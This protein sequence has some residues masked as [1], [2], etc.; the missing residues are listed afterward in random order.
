M[1]KKKA[2]LPLEAKQL[3]KH[4][5]KSA[6]LLSFSKYPQRLFA[7]FAANIS[8]H[9]GSAVK[10]TAFLR[11]VVPAAHGGFP[12]K[13]PPV[14]DNTDKIAADINLLGNKQRHRLGL[15]FIQINNSQAFPRRSLHQQIIAYS[16]RFSG[17]FGLGSVSSVFGKKLNPIL[18]FKF[19]NAPKRLNFN[20]CIHNS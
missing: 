7:S 4:R 20:I 12:E 5:L 6:Q 10:H 16:E 2:A 9:S 15:F 1:T 8:L 13:H 17:G 3:N 11:S 14:A 19:Y 18:L